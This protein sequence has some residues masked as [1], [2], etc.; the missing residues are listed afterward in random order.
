[1]N[2]ATVL[3]RANVEYRIQDEPGTEEEILARIERL[4][5]AYLAM[6]PDL[7][8]THLSAHSTNGQATED[9]HDWIPAFSSHVEVEA[10]STLDAF[11]TS[12]D[13]YEL[14]PL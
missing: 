1:M 6:R 9:L 5:G 11:G 7:A 10:R 4:V 12:C 3:T 2:T 14:F 13:G 8:K